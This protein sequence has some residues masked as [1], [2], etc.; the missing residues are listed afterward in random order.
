MVLCRRVLG[1]EVGVGGLR[2]AHETSMC[3][4]RHLDIPDEGRVQN[5]RET[6]TAI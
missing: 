3:L 1:S 4:P 2:L 5:L 6:I